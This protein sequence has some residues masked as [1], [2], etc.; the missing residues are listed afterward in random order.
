MSNKTKRDSPLVESVLALDGHLAELERVGSKI[1]AAD[2]T[3]DFDLDY[4]QKLLTRFAECGRGISEEV[5]RL[6]Q[7]LQEAQLRADGVAR[8]VSQQ[9]E[10][11]N[12]RKK[13][14]DEKVEQL[15]ALGEKV[16][17]LNAAI[18]EFR[19]ADGA[20]TNETLAGWKARVPTFDAQ[21]AELIVQLQALKDSARGSQMRTLA[22]SAESL[23]QSLEAAR[24][25]LLVG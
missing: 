17:A 9:A 4:I 24:K 14:H 13:A 18:G 23:A 25:R 6:S 7:R 22:K 19:P 21:L 3:S 5:V 10:R 12:A 2:M 16:R 15:R 11:F 20:L 8:G 1:I